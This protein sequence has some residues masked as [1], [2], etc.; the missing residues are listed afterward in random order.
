M[1]VL[2][3]DAIVFRMRD[4]RGE[5]ELSDKGRDGSSRR[6]ALYMERSFDGVAIV[7]DRSWLLA[8]R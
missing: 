2:E 4:C 8:L 1:G 3:S 6:K 7:I 5:R